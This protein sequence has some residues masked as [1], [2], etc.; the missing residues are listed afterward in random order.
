MLEAWGP[1]T[2]EMTFE[3]CGAPGAGP[4]K[5]ALPFVGTLKSPKLW[6]R[7]P[8]ACLPRLAGIVELRPVSAWTA[9]RVP[10]VVICACAGSLTHNALA[11][12]SQ[13]VVRGCGGMR[14]LEAVTYVAC[15]H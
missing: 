4:A 15:A 14:P 7:L 12:A 8:P 3:T 6:K 1:V 10:S 9:P 2:R 13:I 11:T 5:I